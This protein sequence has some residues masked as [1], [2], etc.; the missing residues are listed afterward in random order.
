LRRL[1]SN[2]ASHFPQTTKNT[3]SHSNLTTF[4]SYS[5][6]NP[7]SHFV[8]TYQHSH[9]NL[10]TIFIDNVTI[11][12]QLLHTKVSLHRAWLALTTG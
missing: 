7:Q 12:K 5:A 1:H 10:D 2:R 11:S 6:L 3:N 8:V 4:S 9:H